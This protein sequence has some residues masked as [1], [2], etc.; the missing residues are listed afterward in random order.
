M[1]FKD[2]DGDYTLE[3]ILDAAGQKGTGKW[4]VISALQLGTPLTLIGE[5]VFSRYLS[6]MKEERVRASSI[7]AKPQTHF[8]GDTEVFVNDLERALYASKIV[9]YAQGFALMKAASDEYGWDLK[10]NEIALIWR[11]GCIIRSVFLD[12][13]AGAF[14]RSPDLSNLLLDAY[15]KDIMNEAQA[16][17]RRVVATAVIHAMPAPAMT[18]ALCYFDGLGSEK[19]PANLLQA[20][21]DYFGAHTYER[22]DRSRGEI[23]HTNWTGKGGDTTSSSYN[24]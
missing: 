12:K 6:A 15:F 21:R 8:D 9:S 4:T 13:I 16:N 2:E 11:N 17:W 3:K 18:S 10:H 14:T 24:G 20:Q 22:V 23:F 7:L 19:L 5:S 1:A